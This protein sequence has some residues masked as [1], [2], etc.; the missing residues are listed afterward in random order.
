MKCQYSNGNNNNVIQVAAMLVYSESQPAR[1]PS[2][3]GSEVGTGQE[4]LKTD[5]DPS[6]FQTSNI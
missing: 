6:K 5:S 1:E 3:A 4:T 2:H